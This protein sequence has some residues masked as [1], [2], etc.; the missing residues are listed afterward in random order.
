MLKIREYS[1]SEFV[2]EFNAANLTTPLDLTRPPSPS[3]VAA[4]GGNPGRVMLRGID[5]STQPII[6]NK[7]IGTSFEVPMSI[8][9]P[10]KLTVPSGS[11]TGRNA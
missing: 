3:L 6:G 9:N 2:R 7:S 11:A 4:N 1:I 5:V 10:T 8:R